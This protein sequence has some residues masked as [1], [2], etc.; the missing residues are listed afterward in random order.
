[1]LGQYIPLL[2]LFG[3]AALVAGGVLFGSTLV[4][5]KRPYSAKSEV[6]HNGSVP[7]DTK[8][9]RFSVKFYLVAITFVFFAVGAAFVL[10]WTVV[11]K[12]LGWYGFGAVGTFL[13]VFAL[14]LAYEWKSGG[15]EW[16]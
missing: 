7:L 1:M 5:P 16:E 4:G 3:L 9:R 8:P 2:W 10:P 14:G 13:A 6:S 11:S 12:S 15:L